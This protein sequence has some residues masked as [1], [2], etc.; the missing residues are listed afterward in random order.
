MKS[1]LLLA[2]FGAASCLFAFFPSV[3]NA[4]IAD[5][6]T[7]SNNTIEKLTECVTVEGVRA[8]Q[9][10]LQS[11]ADANNGT[12]SV[13]TQGFLDSVLYVADTLEAAGYLVTMQPFNLT[14]HVK[15]GASAL[16]QVAPGAV[17]YAE[18]ADFDD[19]TFTAQGDVTAAVTAVD[20]QLGLGNFSTSGCEAGDFAGFP[21]GNIALIQRGVC[22]FELKAE[23]AAAAGAVGVII[24]NQGDTSGPDR[25][26]VFSGTLSSAYSG[27]IPVVAASYPRG[28]EWASTPGLVMRIFT[29]VANG[30]V[31]TYNVLAETTSGDPGRV[32]MA[33]AHLDSVQRGPGIQDNGSGSAALLETAVQM[34]KVKPVNKVRFAWWGAEEAGLVGSDYYLA[35]LSAAQRD[36]ITAYLNFDMIG[37]PN[38]VR[39]VLDGDAPVAP[40]GSSAIKAFFAS[41]YGGK[42]LAYEP[43]NIFFATDTAGFVDYGIPVGGV[44]TGAAGIKTPEQ[45]AIYGGTAGEQYDPCYHQPCDT[46]ANISIEALDVNS[47]AVAASVLNYAMLKTKKVKRKPKPV[48]QR[49]DEHGHIL[50]K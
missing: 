3:A 2:P 21:A 14:G 24:F 38:F 33:G 28:Q 23:N 13:G 17:S 26:N 9:S 46:F 4:Q 47:D 16:Q 5:C 27:G 11:A 19:L 18:G 15:L 12:R 41:F 10:A 6:A 36:A 7:R 40:A 50:R 37:S 1:F 29:N 25:Q 8:H 48:S 49:Y 42:G 35:N 44:F 20:L 30:P 43:V 34:A 31:T 39:F 32:L 22:A 45:A